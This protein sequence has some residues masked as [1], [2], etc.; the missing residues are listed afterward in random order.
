MALCNRIS[1]NVWAGRDND[2]R[3]LLELDPPDGPPAPFDLSDVTSVDFVLGG[4]TLTV[5]VN[6]A[7]AP[8]NWW[9]ISLD[10]GEIHFRLGDFVAS[11]S[12]ANGTY[13]AELVLY[14]PGYT[15]GLVWFSAVGR[16]L[17]IRVVA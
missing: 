12:L 10:P 13:P 16:E 2:F 17:L 8:I 1:K 3:L 4:E 5:N 14:A 11:V 9:D 6:D 15:D 7:N